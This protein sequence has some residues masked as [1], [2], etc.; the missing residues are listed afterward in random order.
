MSYTDVDSGIQLPR[1]HCALIGCTYIPTSEIELIKHIHRKHDDIFRSTVGEADP[2]RGTKWDW[3]KSCYIAAIRSI[4]R[5]RTPAHGAS[6]DRRT[7][8]ISCEEYNSKRIKSLVCLCCAQI[9]TSWIGD[10]VNG[11]H[12]FLPTDMCYYTGESFF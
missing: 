8:E 2:K 1:Y 6:I 9:H 3:I 12:E 4:E 10:D 11:F 5:S 7:L